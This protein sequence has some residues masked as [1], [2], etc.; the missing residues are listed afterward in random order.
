MTKGF[1][2]GNL[3][4]S[5]LNDSNSICITVGYR[6]CLNSDCCIYTDMCDKYMLLIL[7]GSH[8][9]KC[10]PLVYKNMK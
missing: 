1:K 7:R 5:V 3:V 4:K 8:I 9:K 6:K 2:Q 10:C